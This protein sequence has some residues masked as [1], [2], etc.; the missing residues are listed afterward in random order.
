M[1]WTGGQWPQQTQMLA[2]MSQ[3]SLTGNVCDDPLGQRQQNPVMIDQQQLHQQIQ[4]QLCVEQFQLLNQLQ[5]TYMRN[6]SAHTICLYI[7]FITQNHPQQSP[8]SLIPSAMELSQSP[9]IGMQ[10]L[11]NQ[12]IQNLPSTGILQ[13]QQS[14]TKFVFNVETDKTSP[15]LQ[16]LFQLPTSVQQVQQQQSS[17]QDTQDSAC[18]KPTTTTIQ[19]PGK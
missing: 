5:V 1:R 16:L 4:Q 19:Y 11:P 6:Y 17:T 3:Q 2:D 18:P 7:P 8:I 14:Q 15:S 10:S 13:Q 9:N 12:Q